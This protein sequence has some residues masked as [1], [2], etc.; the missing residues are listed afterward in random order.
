LTPP[1]GAA[2]LEMT[3]ALKPTM[4]NFDLLGHTQQAVEIAA[5][6]VGSQPV[7]ARVRGRQETGHGVSSATELL[8]EWITKSLSHRWLRR[9]RMLTLMHGS[10]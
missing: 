2:A 4:P 8:A 5:E 6:R 10:T 3:P 9:R 1:K 7:F